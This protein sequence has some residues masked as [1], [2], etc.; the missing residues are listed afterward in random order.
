MEAE[1]RY[2]QILLQQLD[3]VASEPERAGALLAASMGELGGGDRAEMDELLLNPEIR[4]ELLAQGRGEL[5]RRLSELR[6][7][8]ADCLEDVYALERDIEHTFN[9]YWGPL[10][11]EGSEN[12]RIGEQVEDYACLYTSRV[13]NFLAYS[14]FQLFRS[15]RDHLPH[16]RVY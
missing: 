7:D 2:Q 4:S 16:E 15:P 1:Q 10:F 8:L 9:P 6:D 11:K 13:S 5:L 14:P 3:A 12:S